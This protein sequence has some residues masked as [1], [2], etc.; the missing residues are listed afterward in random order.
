M[1][2]R[3]RAAERDMEDNSGGSS[4]AMLKDMVRDEAG[5]T[6]VGSSLRL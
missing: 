5:G 6:E 3:L 4:P 1:T 2:E